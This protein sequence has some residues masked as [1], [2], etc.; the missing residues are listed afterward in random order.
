MTDLEKGYLAG[1]IDGE[2]SVMLMS[3]HSGTFKSPQVSVASTDYEIIN[4]LNEKVPGGCISNKKIYKEHHKPSYTW[5]II[6]D[7]AITFLKEIEPYMLI[8]KKKKRARLIIDEYKKVTIRNGK[9][10]EITL[11]AKLDFEKRFA[12]IE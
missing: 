3:T 6:N 1:L 7:K 5:K 8:P 12:E 4:F 11:A 9:Y 10:N 2:G